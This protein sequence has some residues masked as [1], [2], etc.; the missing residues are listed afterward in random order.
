MSCAN[1]ATCWAASRRPPFTEGAV[2]WTR[3]AWC[4]CSS[5]WRRRSVPAGEATG[6]CR[7]ECHVAAAQPLPGRAFAGRLRDVPTRGRRRMSD[8]PVI[9]ITGT[10]KGIGRALARHYL[11]QGYLVVG[12]SRQPADFEAE[13]Y[14]HRCLDVCDE[15]AVRE[16]LAE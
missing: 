9:L 12:C 16:L 10:R 1:R 13:G 5:T 15:Q 7:R 14:V 8:R 3:S 6:P 11:D 2:P 4:P